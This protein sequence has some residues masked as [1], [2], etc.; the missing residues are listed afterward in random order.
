MK[1]LKLTMEFTVPNKAI[2]EGFSK[3]LRSRMYKYLAKHAVT[4]FK[5]DVEITD[6]E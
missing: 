2:A 3:L 5:M 6:A 4:I 1:R